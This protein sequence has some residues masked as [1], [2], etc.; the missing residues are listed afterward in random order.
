MRHFPGPLLYARHFTP[1]HNS[2]LPTSMY[3]SRK[4]VRF[5][6]SLPSGMC[7]V[8]RACGLTSNP[9]NVMQGIPQGSVLSLLLL[10]IA[11]TALPGALTNHND[12]PVR[13]AIYTDHM[14]LW[15]VGRSSQ[16]TTVCR[17]LQGFPSV[18]SCCFKG[19]GL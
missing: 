1:Q 4:N 7:L 11:M 10:N 17:R 19:L 15:C 9:R 3:T 5:H 16:D 6:R 18:V 8:I 12:L 13:I 14:A 2:C